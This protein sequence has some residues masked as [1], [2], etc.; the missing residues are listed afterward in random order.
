MK[1]CYIYLSI[2][3]DEKNVQGEKALSKN[4]VK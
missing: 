4:F 3:H 1:A 2:D